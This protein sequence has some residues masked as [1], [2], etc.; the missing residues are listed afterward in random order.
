MYIKTPPGLEAHGNLGDV[1]KLMKSLYGLKKS[2]RAWVTWFDTVMEQLSYSQRQTYLTL[3][4]KKGES[5]KQTVLVD[6]M[7]V[8]RDD[9][10][11]IEN[12]KRKL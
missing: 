3:F 7:V 4:I 5:R 11:E 10:Q 6:N 8:T 9:Q 12:P 2:P 1:C